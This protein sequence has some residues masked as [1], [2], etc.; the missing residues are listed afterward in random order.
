MKS[1]ILVK[2]SESKNLQTQTDNCFA[3]EEFVRLEPIKRLSSF[4]LPP[5]Y[6]TVFPNL[7]ALFRTSLS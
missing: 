5:R 6:L 3:I 4:S 7:I 1:L 2:G